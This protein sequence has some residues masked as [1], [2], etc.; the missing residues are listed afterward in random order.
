MLGGRAA[1][2]FLG[3]DPGVEYS[4]GAV[5]FFVKIPSSKPR[6]LPRTAFFPKTTTSF[7][8]ETTEELQTQLDAAHK[9]A[10]QTRKLV[11]EPDPGAND[12]INGLKLLI[13]KNLLKKF[14]ALQQALTKQ[15]DAVEHIANNLREINQLGRTPPD[16]A[17]MHRPVDAL[18]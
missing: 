17:V 3:L 5:T 10:A 12:K 4:H 18:D 13:N 14:D 2:L 11:P 1:E 8:I 7:A 16:S 15:S 9:W 6:H